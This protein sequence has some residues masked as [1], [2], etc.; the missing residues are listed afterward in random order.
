MRGA[1]PAPPLAWVLYVSVLLIATCGLIYELCAGALATYLLGNSVT[2]FSL[3]IGTYLSAMGVGSYLSRFFERDLLARFVEIEII[4]ALVGG[5][6]APL[7]FG[8]FAYSTAFRLLLYGFVALVG[9]GV[10]LELPLLMRILTEHTTL[11]ELVARVM[12]LDYVGALVASV[13]FPV[14][15]VPRLGLLRTSL[16]FG[17]VNAVV[18]LLSTVMF[19][20]PSFMRTRLRVMASGAIALLLLGL[21]G[22]DRWERRIEQ[23]L[24]ADPVVLRAISPYQH[25]TLTSKEGDTRLFLDGGLQFSTLDEFRY[26]ESLVHPAMTAATRH[27][28]VLVL[29]GGDGLAVREV[30]RWPDVQQVTLVDLDPLVTDLFTDRPELAAINTRSLHD[31]RVEIVNADAFLWLQQQHEPYDV[32]IADFPDPNDYGLGKLYTTQFYKLV[33]RV[34]HPDGAFTVQA[35]SPMWSPTAYWCI[36]RTL[37]EVG[38]TTRPYHAYIPSFGEWGFVLA[39]RDREPLPRHPLPAEL[40]FLDEATLRGLFVFPKDLHRRETPPNRLDNQVL[41]RLYEQDWRS[42]QGAR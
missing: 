8:L 3:V 23:D 12:A 32:V 24:F 35:T 7:L 16:V 27:E 22:S 37:G 42:L 10:G 9:I 40:R 30:L 31:P 4:V 1:T 19:A 14:L 41:V 28:R 2:Q 25:L 18:A 38:L 15:L 36:V 11:K 34:L 20:E 17:L 13:L 6:E 29:G 21:W 5:F 39:A 33:L 26:H